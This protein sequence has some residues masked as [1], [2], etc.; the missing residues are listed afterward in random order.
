MLGP[1]TGGTAAAGE[2]SA[3]SFM[4]GDIVRTRGDRAAG[5]RCGVAS[6]GASADQV[7]DRPSVG[8]VMNPRRGGLTTGAASTANGG[9]EG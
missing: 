7:G 5:G 9:V 2:T 4:T 1:L 6:V 8:G 3:A